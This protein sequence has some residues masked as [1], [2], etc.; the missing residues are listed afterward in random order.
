MGHAP[1][2]LSKEIEVTPD[3]MTVARESPVGLPPG[4]F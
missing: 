1:L 4:L 3:T 2:L